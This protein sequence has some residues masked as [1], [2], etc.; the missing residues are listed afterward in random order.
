MEAEASARIHGHS[1]G[2]EVTLCG[3]PDPATGMLVDLGVVEAHLSEVRAALDHRLLDEIADLGPA[4]LENL[5]AWIW[6]RLAA[7][8]DKLARVRVFRESTGDACVYI[9][10]AAL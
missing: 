10:P 8:T 1:Y 3:E 4:T 7:R 6:R 2:V 9:G 5:A